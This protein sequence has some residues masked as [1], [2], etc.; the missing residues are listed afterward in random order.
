MFILQ[1]LAVR[2]DDHLRIKANIEATAKMLEDANT[3]LFNIEGHKR[4]D[5]ETLIPKKIR[6][7]ERD[8]LVDLKRNNEAFANHHKDNK[9]KTDYKLHT[10][11]S[12][13]HMVNEAS[14]AITNMINSWRLGIDANNWLP[15]QTELIV[16]DLTDDISGEEKFLQS[17]HLVKETIRISVSTNSNNVLL[18]VA[19]KI[20][21]LPSSD[22]IYQISGDLQIYVNQAQDILMESLKKT[23]MCVVPDGVEDWKWESITPVIE[24]Q[25]DEFEKHAKWHITKYMVAAKTVSST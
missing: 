13:H 25:R 23:P 21:G 6:D 10:D 16:I 9:E 3:Q 7:I 20:R 22:H 17:C 5:L 4:T 12:Y 15:P 14:T 1:T 19:D 24:E 11:P 2:G 18:E 8:A